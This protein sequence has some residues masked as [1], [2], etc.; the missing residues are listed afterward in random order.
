[1][2][3]HG[4]LFSPIEKIKA[5]RNWG[6]VATLM[7]A[8]IVTSIAGSTIAM[9]ADDIRDWLKAKN[10]KS[11]SKEYYQEM[12]KAHP[13]LKKEKPELVAQY[14]ASLFHFAPFMAADPLSSGAFIR[15]SIRRGL[16]E[17]FGG[18]T[19]DTYS[20]LASINKSLSDANSTKRPFSEVTSSAAGKIIGTGYEN[21]LGLK[22]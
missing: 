16:P 10:L 17:E 14:W 12:L 18:P 5:F 11:K 13:S 6:E 1:M 19:I 8:G 22:K 7:T 20:T 4:T 21:F 3:K 2:K 15:Q 9:F